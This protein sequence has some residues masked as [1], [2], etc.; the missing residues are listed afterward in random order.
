MRL[1]GADVYAWNK[2]E[3]GAWVGYLPQSVELMEGTLAENIARFGVL[4][5]DGILQAAQRAH[6]HREEREEHTQQHRGQPR[7]AGEFAAEIGRAHV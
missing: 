6:R 3:L 4:D 2:S 7:L 1:D 5:T